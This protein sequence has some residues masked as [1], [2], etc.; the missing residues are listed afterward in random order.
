MQTKL[1]YL[2]HSLGEC[3]TFKEC[4]K[5]DDVIAKPL[6]NLTKRLKSLVQTLNNLF[7]LFWLISETPGPILMGLSLADGTVIRMPV[8]I[9][10]LPKAL[11]V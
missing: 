5:S 4:I 3:S 11:E 6:E 10:E 2:S 9:S 8:Y 1:S 7:C